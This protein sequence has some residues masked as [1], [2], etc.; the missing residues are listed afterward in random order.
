MWVPDKKNVWNLAEVVEDKADEST[1]TYQDP[2]H[3]AAPVSLLRSATHPFDPTHMLDLDNLCYINNLHEAPLLDLLRRRF[4]ASNIYTYTGDVLI[5]LNP[6][7]TIPDLYDAPWEFFSM[8]SKTITGIASI[9][10]EA[11]YSS[12]SNSSND[13][14]HR[15]HVFRIAN[16][17][18][19]ALSSSS[20]S[21]IIS[22]TN[23][24]ND[25]GGSKPVDLLPSAVVTLEQ[26][27][28]SQNH[29][30][31]IIIRWGV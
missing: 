12:T 17:A 11:S 9:V 16:N 3:E 21:V 4:F 6:Y 25:I 28:V 23:T 24:V 31:S 1:I 30:Q 20:S 15:P 18:L 19:K 5:S 22:N 10:E 7:A 8:R 29:N 14:V 27:I 2:A 13:R 26:P